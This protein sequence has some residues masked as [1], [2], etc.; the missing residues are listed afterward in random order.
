MLPLVRCIN[1]EW[2]LVSDTGNGHYVD[3]PVLDT[4]D[5]V[6]LG[7][8]GRAQGMHSRS[9]FES[10][11]SIPF[12]W[13]TSGHSPASTMAWWVASHRKLGLGQTLSAPSRAIPMSFILKRNGHA[14]PFPKVDTAEYSAKYVASPV[15]DTVL[16]TGYSPRI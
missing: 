5:G 15:F 4:V 7:G 2:S 1:C 10:P 16:C 8:I 12:V 13:S 6:A 3:C 11:D 9:E 14:D